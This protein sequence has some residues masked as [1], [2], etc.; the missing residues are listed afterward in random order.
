MKAYI[1]VILLFITSS[2]LAQ[3]S[4][5]DPLPYAVIP[6]VPES[7]TPGTVVSR[8]IDGLGFRYYWATEG[9]TQE[10]MQ[11]KPSEDGRTIEQTMD[12]V[13]GLSRTIVNSAKKEPT[14]FTAE[15]EE[16]SIEEKR[17]RTLENF[18]IASDLFKATKD[19]SDHK[20]IFLRKNGQSEFPFWNH[21]N[22]PIEDAVWHAGQIV[23][24]RRAA[25][26]PFNSKVS[27]LAGKV[28]D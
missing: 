11:Y 13:Y 10:N 21:L 6:E 3:E 17:K 22:G 23:M 27:L 18:K 4:M 9:L 1:N 20:I 7:Y 24:M 5:K 14:D 12:H 26:N 19:L 25:G 2:I 28:R 8:M 15:R 16:L